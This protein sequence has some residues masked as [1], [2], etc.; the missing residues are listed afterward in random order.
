MCLCF[1]FKPFYVLQLIPVNSS[2]GLIEATD[3]DS[4]PLYYRLETTTDK[5]FRLENIN[6]PKILVKTVLDYD[7]VQKISLVLHVQDTFNG[8]ASNKPFFTSVATITVRVKDVDNRPPWFH[9]CTRTNLGTAKLCV[10]SGYRGK[11][12]LTE[13]Q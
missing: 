6:T 5:Y 7:V 2:I 13:K 1:L 12:N 4:Q 8:S 9:P 10:S 3:V 11:V